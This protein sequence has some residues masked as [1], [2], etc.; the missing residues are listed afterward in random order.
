MEIRVVEHWVED[1]ERAN[2]A[3]TFIDS[4]VQHITVRRILAPVAAGHPEGPGQ[5]EPAAS[6]PSGLTRAGEA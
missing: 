4:L 2:Q 3:H 5:S 6:G 1:C